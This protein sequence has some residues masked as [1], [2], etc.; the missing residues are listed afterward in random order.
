M[1]H[2]TEEELSLKSMVAEFCARRLAPRV[3]QMEATDAFPADLWRQ[4]GELGLLGLYVP[5]DYGGTA[6]GDVPFM[7]VSEELAKISLAFAVAVSCHVG[8]SSL[9][10]IDS[11]SEEAKQ[12]VLPGLASGEKVG[13]FALT[14]PDYGSDAAAL[15]TTAVRKGDAYVLNGVKTLITNG[16]EADTFVVM[17]RTGAAT[18]G[19]QGVS[20]FLVEKERPGLTAGPKMGKM[21]MK[22]NSTTQVY[23][24]DC[25]IPSGNILGAEG[26]GFKVAMRALDVGRLSVAAMALGVAKR[27]LAVALEYAADRKSFGAPLV[28]HQSIGHRLAALDAEIDH[29]DVYIYHVA[30]NHGPS[31]IREASAAKLFASEVAGRAADAAVQTFGGMGY[32]KETEAERL[33]RDARILRIFEGAS[34]IQQRVLLKHLKRR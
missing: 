23:F 32:M 29:S 13:A 26:E 24:D 22:G 12:R 6:F 19:A 10:I 9:P 27:S 30:R 33:Y 2:F 1:I 18:D 8:V 34:E 20:A 28:D 5:E 21:G 17:A 14:E 4:A 16:T 7:L 25:E 15:R 3:P 11:G 31:Y